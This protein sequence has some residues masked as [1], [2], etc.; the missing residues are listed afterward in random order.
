MFSNGQLELPP[1]NKNSILADQLIA[2]YKKGKQVT[3]EAAVH[4]CQ[5]RFRGG[6]IQPGVKFSSSCTAFSYQT[7]VHAVVYFVLQSVNDTTLKNFVTVVL[8]C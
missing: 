5:L 2:A 8:L 1:C 6:K 7:V 3:G 4:N